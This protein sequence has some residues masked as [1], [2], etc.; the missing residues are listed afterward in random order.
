MR[1]FAVALAVAGSVALIGYALYL[2]HEPNCLWAIFLVVL[3]IKRFP[4][5]KDDEA[6]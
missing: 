1:D 4:G 6:A 3:I 2:T 5:K